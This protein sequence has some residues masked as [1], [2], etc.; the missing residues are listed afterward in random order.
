MR[1]AR[2]HAG[3]N[4]AE[5]A[6]PDDVKAVADWVIAHRLALAPEA[7][8]E[9]VSEHSVLKRLLEQTAVPR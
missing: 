2:I 9:G 7:T 3:L 5:F 8:L 6:A 1:A 4:G